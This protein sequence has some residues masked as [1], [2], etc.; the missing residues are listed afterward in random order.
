MLDVRSLYVTYL[1]K[2]GSVEAVRGI[3][4]SAEAGKVTGIV[5][6]SGSGKS[7]AMLAVMGLL[8]QEAAVEA[9]AVTL[10]ETAVKAGE[11]AAIVFQDPLKCLNPTVKVGRQI[12]ETVRN[13]KKCTWHEAKK[14]AEE[15]LESVGIQHPRLRMKQY[16]FE[17]SGGMRQRVVIAIALACEPKLIIAD[18]PTTALDAA[19]R[20]RTILL[21]K[22]VVK[23]TEA[24]L[25]LVSHDMGVIAA[26]CDYVYVMKDGEMIES[27]CA[28]DLFY[29]PQTEYTKKLL[30]DA[31]AER[32]LVKE[33]E[34]AVGK[35]PLF[36][37]S[38]LKRQFQKEEGVDEVSFDIYEG[39]LFA[40]AGESGS[41]KTTLAKIL[42]GI[43][44]PGSWKTVLSGRR[45]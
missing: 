40:L 12:A 35:V 17:L 14:R 15:L 44:R 28:E 9:K 4:F 42:T 7:T 37:V 2:T 8:G 36:T 19:M 41:G 27:G 34:S 25:V 21:L 23:E 3:D 13:R 45:V 5:G 10:S 30:S 22:K 16:P 18:E 24:A 26:A 39:E 33:K 1:S 32:F 31:K 29:D 43:E 6:E 11:N 38:R 20:I